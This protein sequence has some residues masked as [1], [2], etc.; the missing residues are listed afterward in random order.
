MG[1]RKFHPD[2]NTF[3]E[4]EAEILSARVK[5]VRAAVDHAGE[6][7]RS[8]EISVLG[9]LW[10]YLPAEYGLSTG[11]IAYHDL[12][13]VRNGQYDAS[14]DMIHLSG[15]VD[16]ISTM[17]PVPE[18]RPVSTSIRCRTT[19]PSAPSSSFLTEAK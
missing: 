3:S 10:Q 19:F 9:L 5:G 6:K 11:F 2:I 12:H 13:C 15:Q 8:N 7:G 14:R 1:K 17:G 4:A 18:V 16:I